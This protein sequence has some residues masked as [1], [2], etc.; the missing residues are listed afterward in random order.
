MK[1]IPFYALLL[2]S[3]LCATPCIGQSI[4]DIL[5]NN[6]QAESK[7]VIIANGPKTITR[8]IKQDRNG[9]IWFASW[10]GIIKYNGHSFTNITSDISLDHFFSILEDRK[11][12]LWFAS[13]GSGV[14]FYDGKSFQN[15]TTKDGLANNN[16]IYIYEDRNTNIWFATQG[17]VSRYDGKSFQ[18]YT[19]NEGL[20]SNDINTILEDK[21]GKIWIG[22]RGEASVYDGKTFTKLTNKDGMAFT[23]VRHII[24]D[25]K[26]NIWLGG[27]DGLWRYDGSIFTNLSKKFTGYIYEDKKGNIWTSSVSTTPKSWAISRYDEASLNNKN[28]T[29]EEIKKEQ[30]MLFGILEDFNGNMWF[31]SL[32]GAY[33]YDSNT[34]KSL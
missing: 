19:S 8:T 6:A 26:G 9:N 16:V 2:I 5:E 7:D 29:V 10:E 27:N 31:G 15:F 32:K 12:N 34:I 28:P 14:Y 11:G 33:R 21:T 1:Y 13:I 23:N 17:G 25:K 20:L 30:G 4:T 24:E 22:T 18:N 3:I